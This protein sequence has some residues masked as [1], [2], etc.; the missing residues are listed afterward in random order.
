[1]ITVTFPKRNRLLQKVFNTVQVHDKQ[2][3]SLLT[4]RTDILDVIL[5]NLGLNPQDEIKIKVVPAFKR[6]K[7]EVKN[8]NGQYITI[9]YNVS[10][11]TGIHYV[12]FSCEFPNATRNGYI[13]AKLPISYRT[14]YEDDNENK[15]FNIFLLNV[16]KSKGIAF[17]DEKVYSC[18]VDDFKGVRSAVNDYQTFAYKL[19]RTL[20]INILNYN[21]LD[22]TVNRG[23]EVEA[24]NPF[25]SIK[26]MKDMRNKMVKGKN[27]SSYIIENA[28]DTILYGKTFGNN[29]FE[30]ILMAAA[31]KV[32]TKGNVYL[33]QIKDTNTLKGKK[34]N[35]TPITSA[36]L[37]LLKKLGIECFDELKEYT[38]NEEALRDG[39]ARSQAEFIKNLMKKFGSDE[40]KC[41]LCNCNIQKMIIASHIHRVCDINKE[42]I[43]FEQKRE[44]AVSGDNGLWLCANHDKLFEY[45]LIYFDESGLMQVSNLN[46]L[47]EEQKE[48]VLG[49][50]IANNSGSHSVAIEENLLTDKMKE[51]LS[52]HR[53]R[54]HPE[55]H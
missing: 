26:N 38:P 54:T 10:N 33:W 12:F 21:S 13:V 40:K 34:R 6:N 18:A 37:K 44:K 28:G 17:K 36:N 51:F 45:G 30:I 47:T 1:M 48:Y 55:L 29:G 11:S 14:Y 41:Y 19:C 3:E 5:A 50:T 31:A 16:K 22:W 25:K 52:I 8:Q 43:P 49:I 46:D 39:D 32:I 15:T 42:Q 9:E 53:H 7:K 20:G 27:K 2:D 23:N 4:H 24:Q 35:A